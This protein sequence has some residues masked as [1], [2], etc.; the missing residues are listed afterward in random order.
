MCSRI[1]PIGG[2]WPA[3]LDRAR[4]H[5][6]AHLVHLDL[7]PDNVCIP[8]SPADFDPQVSGQLLRPLFGQ[9]AL[10]DFAFSLV[11]GESL[12]TALPIGRQA[13]Y[14]YQ[15]PRLLRA[16][17]AG[18]RGDLLP[19]RQ[20]DWRCDVFGLAAMLRRYLPEPGSGGTGAWTDRRHAQAQ[21]LIS[22][23][24]DAQRGRRCARGH[25]G[26]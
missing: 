18:R 20:L 12:A 23:L 13:D 26:N 15:S 14:E 22:R 8:L 19:T 16:L 10:I 21:A 4:R 9:I 11:S 17:E 1:A 24:F 3:L 25:T 7:K 6:R 5:P 2:R